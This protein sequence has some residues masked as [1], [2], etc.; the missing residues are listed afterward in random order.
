MKQK[1]HHCS[2]TIYTKTDK[3]IFERAR[4]GA[5]RGEEAQWVEGKEVIAGR[6]MCV[7]LGCSSSSW[8]PLHVVLNNDGI[9]CSPS[10]RIRSTEK[11]RRL[12]GLSTDDGLCVLRLLAMVGGSWILWA[13]VAGCSMASSIAGVSLEWWRRGKD[14]LTMGW[15]ER[16][17]LWLALCSSRAKDGMASPSNGGCQMQRKALEIR[18]KKTLFFF[19][20]P[21]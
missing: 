1:Q 13:I 4:R 14:L 9:L 3:L 16:L 11:R 18:L 21:R 7:R 12:D 10:W 19:L 8:R 2:L 17:P 15:T 6:E 5:C 20:N